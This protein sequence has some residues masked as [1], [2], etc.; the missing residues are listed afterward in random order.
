MTL[1]IAAAVVGALAI[2]AGSV[3][4]FGWWAL[5]VI[6]G[7]VALTWGLLSDTEANA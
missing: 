6:A 3:L 4:T 5:L 1:R 7:S 2:T